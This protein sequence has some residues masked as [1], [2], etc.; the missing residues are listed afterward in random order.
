MP[1]SQLSCVT[2]ERGRAL[3]DGLL[4][5]DFGEHHHQ[6]ADGQD[7]VCGGA[8]VAMQCQETQFIVGDYFYYI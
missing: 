8:V 2:S 3:L 5:L 6:A 4:L 1:L 7:S